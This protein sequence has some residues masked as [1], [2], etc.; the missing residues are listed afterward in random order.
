M[1]ALFNRKKLGRFLKKKRM[2]AGL[3]QYEIASVLGYTSPQFISNIERGTCAPPMETLATFVK[4]Y[5]IKPETFIKLMMDGQREALKWTLSR[6]KINP[7][8]APRDIPKD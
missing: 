5:N 1:H 6:S 8:K 4:V 7:K 3:T 2:E